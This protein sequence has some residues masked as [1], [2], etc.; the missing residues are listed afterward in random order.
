MNWKDWSWVP[1]SK[2]AWDITTHQG[3][4]S[5]TKLAGATF[6]VTLAVWVSWWTYTK[7]FVLE[8]WMLYG[9]FAV[10]H[11]AYDKTMAMRKD[12]Q[13]KKLEAGK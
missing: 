1:F 13:E 10:G 5:L 9:G 12:M 4:Y 8:V 11:A 2:V 6:H 7:G 3:R